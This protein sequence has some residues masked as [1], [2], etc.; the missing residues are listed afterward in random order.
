M[1][2]YIKQYFLLWILIN[3]LKGTLKRVLK[4]NT[5]T[6]NTVTNN[7][8]WLIAHALIYGSDKYF[9]MNFVATYK[10]KLF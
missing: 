4:I 3:C 6:V 8:L 5:Y 2:V 9:K 10:T 7:I 1:C